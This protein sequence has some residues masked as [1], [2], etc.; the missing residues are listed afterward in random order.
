MV[1]TIWLKWTSVNLPLRHTDPK[2]VER[3]K[4]IVQQLSEKYSDP[5]YYGVVTSIAILNEPATYLSQELF[6]VNKQFNYDAYGA[7]RYPFQ[8]RSDKSGLAV[9]IHDGFQPSSTFGNDFTGSQYED[10]ILDHHQYT[11][12]SNA[13]VA[14]DDQKRLNTI[15]G[16]AGNL[17]SSPLWIIVGEWSLATTDCALYLNGRGRGSRYDGSFTGSP[18]VGSCQGKTGDGSNFSE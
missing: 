4:N 11:V 1:S 13:E 9:V 12:F 2:N 3:T 15:C 16:T 14:Y 17:N 10:V 5:Q 7:A 8:G 18:Q 6:S